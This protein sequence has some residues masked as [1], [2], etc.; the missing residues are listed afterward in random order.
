MNLE[1]LFR[2]KR[3]DIDCNI[4]CKDCFNYS[5]CLKDVERLKEAGDSLFK[6]RI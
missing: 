2:E 1:D 5:D 3:K 6:K 4:Q